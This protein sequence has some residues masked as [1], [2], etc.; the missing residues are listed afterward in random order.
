MRKILLSLLA[1]SFFILTLSGCAQEMKTQPVLYFS[2]DAVF[3]TDDITM[4]SKVESFN[5]EDVTVTMLSPDNVNGISYQRVKSTLY[6][7]YNELRCIATNDY[8]PRFS[9]VSVVFDSLLSMQDGT[10]TFSCFEGDFAVYKNQ[11]G[12]LKQT[13]Y[14]DK[15]SGYIYRISAPYANCEITF[16]NINQQ[17]KTHLSE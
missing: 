15:K 5:T 8:L 2:A 4:K 16:S 14:V 7:T 1:I 9:P 12:T 6:I 13:V 11:T 17:K 10:C 3:K